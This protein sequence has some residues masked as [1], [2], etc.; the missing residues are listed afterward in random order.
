MLSDPDTKAVSPCGSDSAFSQTVCSPVSL[1]GDSETSY[2]WPCAALQQAFI[3]LD[4]VLAYLVG[5]PPA[6]AE[7]DA[8]VPGA[9]AAS[10]EAALRQQR[11]VK[12]PY[13]GRRLAAGAASVA[14]AAVVDVVENLAAAIAAAEQEGVDLAVDVPDFSL[15]PRWAGWQLVGAQLMLLTTSAVEQSAA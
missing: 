6:A 4:G 10:Q 9:A 2:L 3:G 5:V 14:A 12:P 8:A 7:L 15:R 11:A 13:V 1:A